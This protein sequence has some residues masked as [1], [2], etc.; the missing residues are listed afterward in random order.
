M[1][2]EASRELHELL[3]QLSPS[4]KLA[5]LTINV[6]QQHEHEGAL[7]PLGALISIATVMAHGLTSQERSTLA[8]HMHAEASALERVW[9]N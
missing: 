8:A 1:S 3:D 5:A 4:E 6:M 2:P 7:A 9:M